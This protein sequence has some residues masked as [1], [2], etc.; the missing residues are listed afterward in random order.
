MQGRVVLVSRG[1]RGGAEG[2]PLD[3]WTNNCS[4][5][6]NIHTYITMKPS[7]RLVD[8][9]LCCHDA[10]RTSSKF[11]LSLYN[12]DCLVAAC[13]SNLRSSASA[14]ASASA[15][16]CPISFVPRNL[17]TVRSTEYIPLSRS[18]FLL[19]RS[20]VLIHHSK[21]VPKDPCPPLAWQQGIA[22]WSWGRSTS[23]KL[24]CM[25]QFIRAQF[26]RFQVNQCVTTHEA[27]YGVPTGIE[28]PQPLHS[29]PS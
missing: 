25:T 10:S 20:R 6:D 26:L 13:E 18:F 5:C 4:S 11:S 29:I 16:G 23:S 15:R 9:P 28:Q 1:R 17:A 8:P 21:P 27:L 3:C 12:G 14:S 7:K 19:A 2:R 24:R 22:L